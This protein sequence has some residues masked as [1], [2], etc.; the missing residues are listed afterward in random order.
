MDTT[1]LKRVIAILS[2]GALFFL[3]PILGAAHNDDSNRPHQELERLVAL[4]SDYATYDS[5]DFSYPELAASAVSPFCK[6]FTFLCHVRCLQRGD[7]KDPT[8]VSTPS[9]AAALGQ[10]MSKGEVNRCSHVPNTNTN[11]VLCLCNNGVDL[12]AEVDYALEGV[13]DIQA[14]GGDGVGT[15]DA[16][17]IRE[18]AY[19][20]TKTLTKVVTATKTV[21][22]TITSVAPAPPPTT[23]TKTVTVVTD[24]LGATP[25]AKPVSTPPPV[26]ADTLED[27]DA[28]R[29][30]DDSEAGKPEEYD[31]DENTDDNE[32]RIPIRSENVVR[33]GARHGCAKLKMDL[34]R[35]L[36]PN[37]AANSK[38]LPQSGVV[39]RELDQTGDLANDPDAYQ[40]PYLEQELAGIFVKDEMQAYAD[41]AEVEAE[42]DRYS[43]VSNAKDEYDENE[44]N[45]YDSDENANQDEYG[46]DES[47]D[48]DEEGQITFTAA[49]VDDQVYEDEKGG[50]GEDDESIKS[51]ISGEDQQDGD[52]E[53]NT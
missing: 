32:N 27:S 2:F 19:G 48:V 45:C 25:T 7:A 1:R 49:S 12:T 16:G 28:R 42:G 14:A 18:V 47:E 36:G 4:S 23:V 53:D 5:D 46:V 29:P 17:K 13:V 35:Q 38:A 44:I 37:L 50:D 52:D 31:D 6:S 15:G 10:M 43:K 34:A 3:N 11:R 26:E 41:E 22:T 20:A 39:A 40:D 24:S 21:T 51:T 9:P 30:D 33:V 8:N